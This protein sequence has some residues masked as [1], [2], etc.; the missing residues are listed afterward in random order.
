MNDMDTA[1]ALRRAVA[2]CLQQIA[3]EMDPATLDPRRSLREQADLDSFDFLRLLMA[4]NERVGVEVPEADYGLVDSLD[5]L[6]NYL[7]RH[8]ASRPS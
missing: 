8:G 1:D 3:P 6:V 2:E 7:G 4:L 5:G